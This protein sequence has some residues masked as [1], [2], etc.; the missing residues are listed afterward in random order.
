M[1]M[2]G[3]CE[4]FGERGKCMKQLPRMVNGEEQGGR[5]ASRHGGANEVMS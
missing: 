1:R 3:E 5:I 2:G 4:R